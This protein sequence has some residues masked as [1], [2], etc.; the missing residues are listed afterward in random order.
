MSGQCEEEEPIQVHLW[1]EEAGARVRCSWTHG[2]GGDL[3]EQLPL[4]HHGSERG[5]DLVVCLGR[6]CFTDV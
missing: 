3:H 6:V 2:R 4:A 1:E 5:N